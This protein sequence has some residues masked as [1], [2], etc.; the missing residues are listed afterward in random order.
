MFFTNGPYICSSVIFGL[1]GCVFLIKVQA[2]RREKRKDMSAIY[3]QG[4][5][6]KKTEITFSMYSTA[7]GTRMRQFQSGKKE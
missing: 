6:T 4:A 5:Q 7:V 1:V 2:P 3:F